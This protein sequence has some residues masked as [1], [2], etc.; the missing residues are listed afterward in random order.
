M[1]VVFQLMSGEYNALLKWPFQ[2][3]ITITIIHQTDHQ[4]VVKFFTPDPNSSSSKK[5]TNGLCNVLSVL[6]LM[7]PL[8]NLAKHGYVKDDVM[9]ISCTGCLHPGT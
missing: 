5:P 4:H 6:L 8:M 3:Q 9:F 1:D 2:Y 7:F